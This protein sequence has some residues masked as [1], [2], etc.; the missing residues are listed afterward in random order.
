MERYND[1]ERGD[2]TAFPRSNRLH[3]S[4]TL[5]LRKLEQILR[6]ESLP[7][8]GTLLDYGC[9]NKPYRN[10]FSERFSNYIGADIAG[11]PD[12]ELTLKDDG[13][14]PSP[15]GSFDCVLSSQV[16][17]HVTNPEL[18]LREAF[19][20]LRPGGS[21]VIS[22]HGMWAY[23]PDPTDYWRWTIDGLQL[24]IK[25][26]GFEIVIVKGVFGP[27]SVAL[28]LWQ[29]STLDR[30]PKLIQRP[31]T[32]FFQTLIWLIER[33]HPDKLSEDASIYLVVARKPMET[34]SE[35]ESVRL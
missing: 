5:L 13:T 10:L 27:E 31:Y 3:C 26:V 29:D 35:S 24:Q 16:L 32:W 7:V 6:S 8:G 21:L 30:L 2:R 12:A 20:V 9:G 28:Q 19:R 25:L 22:T 1:N 14:L 4:L 18:Y 11:N 33:R 15:D 23:H 17:E 34:T